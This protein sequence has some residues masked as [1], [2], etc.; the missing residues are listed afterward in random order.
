MSSFGKR[1]TFGVALALFPPLIVAALYL[2]G[3]STECS[4]GDCTGP[5]MGVL[6]LGLLA[7]PVS[8]AGIVWTLTTVVAEIFRRLRGGRS[9]S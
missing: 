4:G 3:S 7:V 9:A 5:M 8:L 2:Y 6:L 1:L